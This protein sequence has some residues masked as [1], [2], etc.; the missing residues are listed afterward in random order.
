MNEYT[1]IIELRFPNS[2]YGNTEVISMG[3]RGNITIIL[4]QSGTGKTYIY[5]KHFKALNQT[6]ME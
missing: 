2:T 1:K 4:G 5:L 3:L 6:V